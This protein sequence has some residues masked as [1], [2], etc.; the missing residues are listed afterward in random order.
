[1]FRLTPQWVARIIIVYPWTHAR[2][3]HRRAFVANKKRYVRPRIERREKLAKI[4]AEISI[5]GRK[6]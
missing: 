6:A 4:T 3:H 2:A 5:S 1:M